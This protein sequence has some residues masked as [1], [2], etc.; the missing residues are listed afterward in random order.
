MPELF[1]DMLDQLEQANG[2]GEEHK[3]KYYPSWTHE[4]LKYLLECLK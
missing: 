1:E 2:D 3:E 4:D